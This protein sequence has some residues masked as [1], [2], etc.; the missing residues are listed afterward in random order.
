MSAFEGNKTYGDA[1]S[2][3]NI[4]PQ[5]NRRRTHRGVLMFISCPFLYD[6]RVC[7][8]GPEAGSWPI[9]GASTVPGRQPMRLFIAVDCMLLLSTGL[10]SAIGSK[11]DG[12]QR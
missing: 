8:P 4:C 2:A 3:V 12:Q 10:R 1:T 11:R 5:M 6:E 7:K 9:Q